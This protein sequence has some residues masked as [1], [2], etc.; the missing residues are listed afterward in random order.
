MLP[1]KVLTKLHKLPLYS[2]IFRLVIMLLVL[3]LPADIRTIVRYVSVMFANTADVFTHISL[4]EN[5]DREIAYSRIWVK[6]PRKRVRRQTIT[7]G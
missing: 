1:I 3:Y 2:Y 6:R 7:T 4:T 5:N